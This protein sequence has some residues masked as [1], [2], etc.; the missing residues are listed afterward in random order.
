MTST[1][2][3]SPEESAAPAAVAL[4]SNAAAGP[5]STAALSRVRRLVISGP[6]GEIV[7]GD[8]AERHRGTDRRAGARVA[9]PHHGGAGV[10]RGVQAGN[11]RAVRAQHPRSRVGAQATLGAEITRHDLAGVVRR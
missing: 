8:V 1:G 7:G 11:D 3:W 5:A 6:L 9:V 4:A 2:T 10:A